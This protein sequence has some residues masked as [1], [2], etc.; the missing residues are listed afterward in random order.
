MD[1]EVCLEFDRVCH[2]RIIV[3]VFKDGLDSVHRYFN[4]SRQLRLF[5]TEK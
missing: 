5:F 1:I 3:V 4:K 2:R